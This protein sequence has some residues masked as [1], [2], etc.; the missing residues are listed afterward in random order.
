M[1]YKLYDRKRHKSTNRQYDI[2]RKQI[3]RNYR[4]VLLAMFMLK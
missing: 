1:K 4:Y 3:P 2:E